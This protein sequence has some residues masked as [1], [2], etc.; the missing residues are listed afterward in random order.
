MLVILCPNCGP[1]NSDEF[2]YQG[3]LRARPDVGGTDRSE[4]RRYL[5]MRSNKAGWVSERWFHLS[6]CRRF[7]MLERH[8]ESNEIRDV[9]AVGGEQT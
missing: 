3:E 1:R 7:L 6:G 9:E 5:Y 4:W 2:V 8:T